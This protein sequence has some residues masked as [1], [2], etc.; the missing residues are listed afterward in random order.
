MK[1][2]KTKKKKEQ[3]HKETRTPFAYVRLTNYLNL[4]V[5]VR[6]LYMVYGW[7][8]K[9]IR[10]FLE[11]YVVLMQEISD[12]RSSVNEFIADTLQLTGIDVMELLE[13]AITDEQ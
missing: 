12:H 2:V 9:R 7:R 13:E 3:I 8:E 5:I 4:A 10:G 1:R 6:T 11:S